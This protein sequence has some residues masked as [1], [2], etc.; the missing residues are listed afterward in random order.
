MA[1]FQF[2]CD[3][4]LKK[5][6]AED[7]SSLL[8][9]SMDPG[10]CSG[11]QYKFE[12]DTEIGDEDRIVEKD[13]VKVIVDEESLKLMQGSQ[14]DFEEELIRSSFAIKNNPQASNACGCGSSV[15]I[16]LKL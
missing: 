16:N 5:L 13:G 3:K 11:F 10:G 1:Y 4:R 2:S 6:Y 14:L 12:F 15:N 8:R 9:V 7:D